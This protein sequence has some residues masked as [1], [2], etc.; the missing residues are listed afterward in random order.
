MTISE[1]IGFISVF[2]KPAAA[3]L[4]K[5]SENKKLSSS[6]VASLEKFGVSSKDTVGQAATKVRSHCEESMGR[7]SVGGRGAGNGFGT[8]RDPAMGGRNRSFS[9]DGV[10]LIDDDVG[11]AVN[12]YGPYG[13]SLEAVSNARKVSRVSNPVH[14]A[15]TADVRSGPMTIASRP[16]TDYSA[17]AGPYACP[18]TP[19]R[20]LVDGMYVVSSPDDVRDFYVNG[21]VL[22]LRIIGGSSKEDDT[23]PETSRCKALDVYR[24]C[25]RKYEEE[26]NAS[27]ASGNNLIRWTFYY[28]NGGKTEDEEMDDDQPWMNA[29][30]KRK[31]NDPPIQVCLSRFDGRDNYGY[32]MNRVFT[33]NGNVANK[34]DIFNT[35][36]CMRFMRREFP[37]EVFSHRIVRN[38]DILRFVEKIDNVDSDGMAEAAKDRLKRYL[39]NDNTVVI[40]IRIDTLMEHGFDAK[41]AELFN[42]VNSIQ[43][44]SQANRDRI[45][46]YFY[47]KNPPMTLT[48]DCATELAAAD[49]KIDSSASNTLNKFITGNLSGITGKT[50]TELYNIA[51]NGSGTYG[52]NKSSTALFQIVRGSRFGYNEMYVVKSAPSIE[53][54]ALPLTGSNDLTKKLSSDVA[55]FSKIPFVTQSNLVDFMLRQGNFPVAKSSMDGRHFYV[56]NIAATSAT[57]KSGSEFIYNIR[58]LPEDIMAEL[59]SGRGILLYYKCNGTENSCAPP[60]LENMAEAFGLRLHGT[61]VGF[62]TAH[63]HTVVGLRSQPKMTHAQVDV[64]MI[65]GNKDNSKAFPAGSDCTKVTFDNLDIKKLYHFFQLSKLPKTL[66]QASTL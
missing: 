40:F 2:D 51:Y 13:A 44:H 59:K 9:L 20:V 50:E 36:N 47:E 54:Q 56:R 33:Y 46:Y 31:Q 10:S 60:Q 11:G 17:L 57:A 29:G 58:E 43:K 34:S 3:I 14:D 48:Y 21:D 53:E 27:R 28:D 5:W 35:V 63:G 7:K 39:N 8:G 55:S 32:V 37:F 45:A 38:N 64:Y 12:A 18:E 52:G 24:K 49:P 1:N 23:D 16:L 6:E 61:T 19:D 42:T 4:R 62:D 30:T 26:F 41:F 15:G 66:F 65:P 25:I 22:V